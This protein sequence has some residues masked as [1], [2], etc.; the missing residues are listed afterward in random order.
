MFF[1]YVFSTTFGSFLFYAVNC[2]KCY[3]IF[4]GS[5]TTMW[6]NGLLWWYQWYCCHFN[7]REIFAYLP[8]SQMASLCIDHCTCEDLFL[9]RTYI[10][11]R[12]EVLNYIQN[13]SVMAMP[14]SF[15]WQKQKEEGKTKDTNWNE[16]VMKKAK[17]SDKTI[18]RIL[19]KWM[20]TVSYETKSTNMI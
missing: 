11:A 3:L 13:F 20:S 14:H 8:F 4:S 6:I 12:K 15:S 16:F 7:Y 1:N 17:T 18:I 9:I 5:S 19:H 2:T 10:E